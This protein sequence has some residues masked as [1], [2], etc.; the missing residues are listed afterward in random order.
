MP[1]TPHQLA[2]RRKA[3]TFIF[4]GEPIHIEYYPAAVNAET[5]QEAQDIQTRLIAASQDEQA[6][7]ADAQALLLE[8]GGWLTRVLASWD[9]LED[10]SDDGTPGPMV[11]ITAERLAHEI[12][13]FPDFIV[14]IINAI[15][16]DFQQGKASGADSSAPSG[17][18]SSPKGRS[19]SST[20]TGRSRKRS[21]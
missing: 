7:E 9:Y 4:A 19:R 15:G 12:T 11:P 13:R 2:T 10:S 21:A 5:M 17:A 20:A 14:A 1:I 3:V 16:Q 18:T 6:T 8:L